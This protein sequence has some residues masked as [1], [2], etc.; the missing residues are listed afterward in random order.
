V[1]ALALAIMPE[2][3][4]RRRAL[5]TMETFSGSSNPPPVQATRAVLTVQS[6]PD[7]GR[8]VT[9]STTTQ[10]SLGRAEECT[11]PL[12]DA[13]LSRVHAKIQC[14]GG[15]W[16][17][18]D[19]GST[20]GTFVNGTR[21]EKYS[22]LEDGARI[23]LGGTVSARFTFVT[24]DEE[25]ALQ[26]VYDAAMRDGLTELYNR[27]ALEERLASEWAFAAR[28]RTPLSIVWLDVDNFKTINDRYGHL[29]GD[30]VLCE[31][32][33]RLLAAVRTE[34]VAGRYGGEEFLVVARDIDLGK[35]TQLAER[36]RKTLSA[37]P[38]V[39]EANRIDVTASFG[40]ASVA[41]CG[42]D[43]K[44]RTLLEIADSRLYAAKR[45]G[46]NCVVAQSKA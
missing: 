35:A 42:D 9:L 23:L 22:A 25:R 44:L 41:C 20:N 39:H 36:L 45:N 10:N 33:R 28:H 18:T 16:L 17:I 11:I 1:I 21:V 6:G 38:F 37:E 46:R 12:A 27:K 34:D 2:Q 30:A 7:A 40:V 4:E 43:R 15:V 5:H 3:D 26:R 32:A 31:V 8:V 19:E 13:R 29:T 24:V 14:K